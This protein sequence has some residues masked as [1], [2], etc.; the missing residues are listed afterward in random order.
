M[1]REDLKGIGESRVE[2]EVV[3]EFERTPISEIEIKIVMSILNRIPEGKI[4]AE[5]FAWI[6]GKVV[7]P[8]EEVVPLRMTDEGEVQVLLFPRPDNDP[9]WPGKLHNLGVVLLP[10]DTSHEGAAYRA[11]A[12]EMSEIETSGPVLV[13]GAINKTN[14]G[15]ETVNIYWVEVQGEAEEGEWHPVSDLPENIVGHQIPHILR[16]AVCYREARAIVGS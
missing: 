9:V 12:K 1:G 7:T 13:G 3:S 14:R 2:G 4:P 10:S 11:L 16:A 6:A 15:T 5:I 8:C